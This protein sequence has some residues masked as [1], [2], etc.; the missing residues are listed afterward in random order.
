MTN[1]EQIAQALA[2]EYVRK[3]MAPGQAPVVYANEYIKAYQQII[4]TLQ[5]QH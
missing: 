4:A 3:N 2:V 1:I 5:V